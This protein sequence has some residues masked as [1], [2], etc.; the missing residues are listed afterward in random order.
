[1][2]ALLGTAL[3]IGTARGFIAAALI[4]VGF[5]VKLQVEEARMRETFPEYTDYCRRT[6]R[7]IPGLF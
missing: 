6:A 4:L 2:L 3:A 5:I 1:M 7:L